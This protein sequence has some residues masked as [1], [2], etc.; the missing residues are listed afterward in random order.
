[1]DRWQ[2]RLEVAALTHEWQED[3]PEVETKDANDE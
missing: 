3:L 1:M 2:R